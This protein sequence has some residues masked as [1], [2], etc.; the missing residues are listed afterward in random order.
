M[1]QPVFSPVLIVTYG[2]LK[3]L[4]QTIRSLKENIHAYNTDLYVASDFQKTEADAGSVNAVR[5][6]LK[7]IDGFLTVTIFERE[8]NYGPA[9]NTFTALD[10]I[11]GK[12]DRVIIMNDDIV[13][14]P[15]FLKFI[16]EA[17]E[18]YGVD[19][20]VFSISGYCPPIHIP[21]GYRY[22]AF[23]LGRMSAWGCGLTKDRYQSVGPIG[24]EEYDAFVAD[25]A[26][27]NAFIKGGGS[28]MLP[29]LKQV[30]YGL[31][32]AWDVR[33]MYTQFI[34]N[35]YTIYPTQS[36]VQNIGFDGTGMNCGKSKRFDVELNSK[37]SFSFP[38]EVEAN[39]R[40]VKA[41]RKFRDEP[42]TKP[43]KIKIVTRMIRTM[44][45]KFINKSNGN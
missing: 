40:I 11:Y 3:H 39:Q 45:G 18:K 13:T 17:F 20:Q 2:R 36:L 29:M 27:R 12:H 35:Q 1:N 42:N 33:C 38:G 25:E 10:R 5:D 31:L 28:D 9:Q 16:N 7:H 41:Y 6:Y 26:Q 22:D 44:L 34:N 14:A 8:R 19:E 4:Q 24:Q 15:G 37:T 43:S 32:E 21:S 30:A 23:F